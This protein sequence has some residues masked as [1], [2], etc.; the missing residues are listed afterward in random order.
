MV[1]TLEFAIDRTVIRRY[2]A[3]QENFKDALYKI[4]PSHLR[5]TG[6]PFDSENVLYCKPYILAFWELFFFIREEPESLAYTGRF[7]DSLTVTNYQGNYSIRTAKKRSLPNDPLTT[8]LA[9]IFR[10]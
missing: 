6:L 7:L 2:D 1:V 8:A 3:D 5:E 4:T 9:K 10:R